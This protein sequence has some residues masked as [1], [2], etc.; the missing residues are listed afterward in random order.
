VGPTVAGEP[1]A[2]HLVAH[3]ELA[4]MYLLSPYVWVEEDRWRIAV[5]AV[6]RSRRTQDKIARIHLGRS[7]DGINFELDDRAALA[8][9][10]DDD[11]RDGCEDPT[12]VRHDGG[13]R[14]F[15]SGW[16]QAGAVG[17][18]LSATAGPDPRILEKQGRVLAEPSRFINAKESSLVRADDGSWRLLFEYA[19][20]GRS[21]VGLATSPSL[22]GPW[23]A[24]ADPFGRRRGMWDA[25]HLSPGPI[26][27][28][29]G[30]P[31]LFYNGANDRTQ[32][33]I[34]WAKLDGQCRTIIDRTIAP[35]IVPPAVTGDDSDIA[36]CS[37]AVQNDRG[38][39]LYY[40]ISDRYP[41]R[42]RME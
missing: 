13:Y 11:D 1:E 23:T 32:W 38:I 7:T 42:V 20:A 22:G 29:D 3:G 12:M 40:T 15:Y 41:F 28:V 35:L 39:W 10:P 8:P 19:I 31:L 6:P 5:R 17:H 24:L 16:N 2:L 36:F 14:I 37:S 33:R 4:R 18:L 25:V 9:G 27:A 30:Q 26:V 34:G 21:A